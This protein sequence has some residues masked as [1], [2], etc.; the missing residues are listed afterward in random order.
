MVAVTSKGHFQF[1]LVFRYVAAARGSL[2]NVCGVCVCAVAKAIIMPAFYVHGIMF[3]AD[4]KN[5][6]IPPLH[7]DSNSFI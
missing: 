3:C 6:K 1:P 2:Y 4:A 7:P 5:M